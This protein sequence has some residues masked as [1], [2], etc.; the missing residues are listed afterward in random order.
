MG[1]WTLGAWANG[2]VGLGAWPWANGPLGLGP[3]DP[4][5]GKS[6]VPW[7]ALLLLL[8]QTN[9]CHMIS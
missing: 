9:P 1:P 8:E 6:L 5:H 3:M 4:G 2:P 7:I